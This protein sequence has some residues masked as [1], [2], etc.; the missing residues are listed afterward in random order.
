M[1]LDGD[2]AAKAF[3][4]VKEGREALFDKLSKR[5]GSKGRPGG[6]KDRRPKNTKT[7][8]DDDEPAEKKIK[9]NDYIDY[10]PWIELL[11]CRNKSPI[12]ALW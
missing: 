8:F 7:K 1:A 12:G 3:Q 11:N 10:V 9:G 5:K 2:E 4:K 6:R